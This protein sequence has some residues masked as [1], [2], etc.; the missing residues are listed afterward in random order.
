VFLVNCAYSEI[1]ALRLLAEHEIITRDAT[2]NIVQ[3]T[4][5]LNYNIQAN[6]AKDE[7]GERQVVTRS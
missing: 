6:I 3:M 4:M 7:E 5:S 1:N 2:D